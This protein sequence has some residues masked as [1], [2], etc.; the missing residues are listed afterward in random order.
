MKKIIILL[1]LSISQN[2]NAQ[3]PSNGYFLSDEKQYTQSE[4]KVVINYWG[5]TSEN[6]VREI[7]NIKNGEKNG[8]F[9]AFHRTGE[10]NWEGNYLN[11]KKHGLWKRYYKN[12][13]LNL[14]TEYV[15]DQYI[16]SNSYQDGRVTKSESYDAITGE[17]TVKTYNSNENVIKIEVY[18]GDLEK[19]KL[20]NNKNELREEGTIYKRKKTGTTF[21]Y[22]DN[23]LK[24][25]HEYLEDKS[26]LY[27][28]FDSKE[29]NRIITQGKYNERGGKIGVWTYYLKKDTIGHII[30]Y[31]DGDKNGLF[32]DFHY[33]GK[34]KIEGNYK[35]GKKDGEWK[36]YDSYGSM[37]SFKVFK[38]GE[39]TY[40]ESTIGY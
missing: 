15:N 20:F 2:I 25:T 33:N 5:L 22:H 35:N 24:S 13:E 32:Q 39:L 40:S 30:T 19:Y 38:D 6:N 31:K 36:Y 1:I 34:M 29:D 18:K 4:T 11:N 23:G 16:E 10:L 9:K 8:V 14:I 37:T 21:G 7:I 26:C 3:Y 12:G 17:K 27:T 28:K